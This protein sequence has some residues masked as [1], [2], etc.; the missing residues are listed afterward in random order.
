MAERRTVRVDR[1][2]EEARAGIERSA[3]SPPA[4][5]RRS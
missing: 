4:S 5:A 2:D 1:L 3:G